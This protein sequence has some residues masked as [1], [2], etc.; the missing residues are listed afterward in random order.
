MINVIV[1]QIKTIEYRSFD[2]VRLW[3]ILSLNG[4]N[5]IPHKGRE[6]D[7]DKSILIGRYS[8]KNSQD[9]IEGLSDTLEM[10]FLGQQNI[11]SQEEAGLST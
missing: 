11:N 9:Q 10:N 3:W 6:G 2:N 8:L 4:T 7:S 1:I 5:W